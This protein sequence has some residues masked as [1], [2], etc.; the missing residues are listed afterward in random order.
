MHSGGVSEEQGDG[1]LD[2][3]SHSIVC[4]VLHWQ[5]QTEA[6]ILVAI[7]RR[8]T[9]DYMQ[10]SELTYF[11]AAGL[12]ADWCNPLK[13]RSTFSVRKIWYKDGERR[14]RRP[15][16]WGRDPLLTT[17]CGI[18]ST[19]KCKAFLRTQLWLG[20]HVIGGNSSWPWHSIKER[21]KKV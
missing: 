19:S 3:A 6:R 15:R 1:P 7:E 5:R 8:G 16:E 11:S 20:L 13:W 18:N 2:S 17:R 21:K 4:R 14:R 10:S 9:V 12:N